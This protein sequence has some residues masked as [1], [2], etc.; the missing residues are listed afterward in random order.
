MYQRI[1]RVALPCAVVLAAALAGCANDPE[2]RPS[3]LNEPVDAFEAVGAPQRPG[4]SAQR[5]RDNLSTDI[6]RLQNARSTY[7]HEQQ[8]LTAEMKRR[9]AECRKQADSRQVEIQDGSGDPNA[10]YCQPAD[11]SKSE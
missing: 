9:Q 6:E 1:I 3:V 2:P 11:D 4:G 5:D 8:R 10:T 7:E